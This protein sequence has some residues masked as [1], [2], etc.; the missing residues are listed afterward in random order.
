MSRQ[1]TL[2]LPVSTSDRVAVR[3]IAYGRVAVTSGTGAS[4][5]LLSRII[6]C[7]AGGCE[8]LGGGSGH[9]FKI[10]I[11]IIAFRA[12]VYLN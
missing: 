12:F 4:A 6:W 8:A 1:T 3:R 11:H 2:S 7:C 9:T 10:T 5:F